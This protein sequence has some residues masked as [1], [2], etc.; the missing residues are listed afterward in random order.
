[1]TEE[2]GDTTVEDE[3][4]RLTKADATRYVLEERV[5]AVET[6][7]AVVFLNLETD[8][9][10][11]V[12][13]FEKS[14]VLKYVPLPAGRKDT[15]DCVTP[16]EWDAASLEVL[17]WLRGEGL[18]RR[19]ETNTALASTD[20]LRP[21]PTVDLRPVSERPLFF[22]IISTFRFFRVLFA[23]K[24]LMRSNSISRSVQYVRS[25][26]NKRES[27]WGAG[28]TAELGELMS[29]FILLRALT[30]TSRDRCVFDSLVL[31][32]FLAK[33]GLEPE[34]KIGVKTQPFAS[35]CWVQVD[36]K[37]VNELEEYSGSFY[38]I[39]AA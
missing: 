29:Q 1:M 27:R 15:E 24:A 32:V 34:L 25:V 12:T 28:Y 18:I 10:S 16:Y 4:V 9:Y 3:R 5:R 6:S 30:Y 35:H 7:N 20:D 38:E 39:I 8:T 13:D 23:A 37:I 31:S 11:A 17:E 14:V 26:K 21:N 19:E 22:R 33:N 36:G 2:L